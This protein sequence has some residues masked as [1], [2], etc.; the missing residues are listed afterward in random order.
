MSASAR[1]PERRQFRMEKRARLRFVEEL[2]VLGIG[3]GPAAL[4]VM[5]PEG[6]NF[7]GNAEFVRDRKVDAFALTSIPQGCIVYF[8]FWFHNISRHGGEKYLR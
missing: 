3:T 8:D 6:V 4:D 1:G 5:N 7:F 2:D